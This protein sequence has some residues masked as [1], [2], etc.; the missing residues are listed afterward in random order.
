M[1]RTPEIASIAVRSTDGQILA[2][3]GHSLSTRDSE[4]DGTVARVPIIVSDKLR[5]YFE[6]EFEPLD[7]SGFAGFANSEVRLIVFLAS[8]GFLTYF[9]YSTLLLRRSAKRNSGPVPRRVREALDSFSEGILI[10]DRHD[11]IAFANSAFAKLSRQSAEDL[12][13]R[14]ASELCWQTIDDAETEADLPWRRS[15]VEQVPQRNALLKLIGGSC[16]A[17]LLSV[18]TTPIRDD[19]GAVLGTFAT[20]NDQ[21]LI[22]EKNSILLRLLKRLRQSRRTIREKNQELQ[23]LATRDPLTKCLNR[24]AFVA[25]LEHHWSAA[26]R[27]RQ[28]LGC[29][30]VDIDH[31][32]SVNDRFGHSVGDEVLVQVARALNRNCRQSDIVCRYGGEEFCVLATHTDEPGVYRL[33]EILRKAI[34]ELKLPQVSV[35]ASFGVSSYAEETANPQAMLDQADAALYFAKDSGR[36]RVN[37]WND[38]I[39]MECLTPEERQPE[40]ERLAAKSAPSGR[41]SRESFPKATRGNA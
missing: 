7:R 15:Y 21:T 16:D 40:V 32:K 30:L 23:I 17:S 3:V 24:R 13:G 28:A 36:N 6:V 29:I 39:E 4:A 12:A 41:T 1:A 5:A 25:A 37:T 31:F 38:V 27:Y 2:Q 35:T 11:R 26:V 22:Q 9:C 8:A 18:N 33:A 34:A 20:L 10:L 14:K 19:S